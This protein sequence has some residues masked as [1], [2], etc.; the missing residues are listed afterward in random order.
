M[1]DVAASAASHCGVQRPFL[2]FST[3]AWAVFPALS[4]HT[5]T[6]SKSSVVVIHVA[7]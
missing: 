3:L 2:T 4:K 1:V 6:S 5:F 7:L